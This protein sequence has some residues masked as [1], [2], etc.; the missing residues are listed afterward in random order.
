MATV[1]APSRPSRR[2]DFDIGII[3]ALQ[4]EYDAICLVIDEFWDEDGDL[5]GRVIGDKNYYTTGCIG[6]HNVVVALLPEMGKANAAAVAANFRSSYSHL[7]LVLLVGVCGG[8]PS[9]SRRDNE[10]MLGD[11]V[12]SKSVVQYD[13]GRK[14]NDVFVR[15]D[16]LEGN[17]DRANKNIRSLIRNFETQRSLELLQ[18][19]TARNLTQLQD[20]AKSKKRRGTRYKY[21]YPGTASDRLFEPGYLHKH[22]PGYGCNVCDSK[23][24]AICHEAHSTY[25]EEN[26][27]DQG[28]VISR[29]VHAE[30]QQLSEEQAQEPVIHIGAIASG[31]SVMK[32][33][34]ERDKISQEEGVI[35]FEME[36]AGIWEEVPSIIIKSV[37]DYADGHKIGN[38]KDFAA[39]VAAAAAKA[40]LGRYIKTDRPLEGAAQQSVSTKVSETNATSTPVGED[41]RQSMPTGQH[42]V[43]EPISEGFSQQSTPAEVMDANEDS[44]PPSYTETC[45]SRGS[46][47]RAR[48]RQ[49]DDK[50]KEVAV[51]AAASAN[52]NPGVY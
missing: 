28:R 19:Q 50:P 7:E 2:D 36:G 52:M 27:C 48:P 22:R 43:T 38:W 30:K 10:I 21:A 51:R 16:T 1:T 20:K 13:F 15:K 33:G 24:D 23:P 31:D 39:A 4:E 34:L 41:A 29:D 18:T 5:Y 49:L 14:Y 37:C 32:S 42:D 25:C 12:I 17:L 40:L 44:P 45:D 9:P 47:S 3:C 35:A 26:G 46:N 8:V 11:V 6:K